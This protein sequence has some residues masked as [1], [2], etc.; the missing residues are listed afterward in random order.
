MHGRAYS[1]PDADAATGAGH[2]HRPGREHSE[3]ARVPLQYDATGPA[4]HGRAPDRRRTRTAG[5]TML[6]ASASLGR[7]RPPAC[8]N[9]PRYLSVAGRRRGHCDGECRDRAGTARAGSS[10][11]STTRRRP[12][13]RARR[14]SER[15]TRPAGTTGRSWSRS[16]E[17]TRRRASTAHVPTYDGPDS[18]TASLSGTCT[19]RA[20]NRSAPRDFGLKY[21]E[22]AP[23]VTG[24]VPDRSPNDAGWYRRPVEVAS[25]GR[26]DLGDRRL[27][28]AGYEVPT[29]QRRRCRGPAPTGRGTRADRS[30]STS[31]TT[32]R[33]PR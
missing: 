28:V 3:R 29:P 18:A 15:R 16:A 33:T 6:S 8:R 10:H 30:S 23:S 14:H 19:D 4:C 12:P 5:T 26:L 22:T 31:S 1:G 24:A 7:T 13:P 9:A 20:G 11:S 17:R 21:D 25:A 27:L 32:R 2:L